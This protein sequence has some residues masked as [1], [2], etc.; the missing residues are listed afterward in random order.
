M[1]EEE[2][3]CSYVGECSQ[4]QDYLGESRVHGQAELGLWGE[5][6]GKGEGRERDQVQQLG[7]QRFE[8]GGYFSIHTD[9]TKI[10]F[11]G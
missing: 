8:R 7:G 11:S 9:L 4:R 10:A 3:Y 6:E 5:G 1:V 2:G